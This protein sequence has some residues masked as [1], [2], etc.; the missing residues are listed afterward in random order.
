MDFIVDNYFPIIDALEAKVDAIEDSVFEASVDSGDVKRI[1]GLRRRLLTLRR[2]VSP[3]LEMCNR[4][5]R[6]DLQLIDEEM[7]P[8][9]RTVNVHVHRGEEGIDE[10]RKRGGR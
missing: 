1:H 3:L 7:R 6:L 5:A 10:L 8:D 4:L 2:A 9:Y